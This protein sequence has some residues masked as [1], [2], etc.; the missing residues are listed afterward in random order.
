M[1]LLLTTWLLDCGFSTEILPKPAF[2]SHLE[3]RG[4]EVCTVPSVSTAKKSSCQFPSWVYAVRSTAALATVL[5]SGI[6]RN[7]VSLV[8]KISGTDFRIASNCMPVHQAG[9][10]VYKA[11]RSIHLATGRYKIAKHNT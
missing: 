11:K 9:P 3:R 5:Y 6:I 2:D 8:V 1:A 4:T 7:R 10:C